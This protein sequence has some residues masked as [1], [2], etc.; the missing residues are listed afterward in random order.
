MLGTDRFW[1]MMLSISKI[2]AS[3]VRVDPNVCPVNV[4][5]I[6]SNVLVLPIDYCYV[7]KPEKHSKVLVE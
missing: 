7:S 1:N 6:V 5:H 2:R 4:M 3:M